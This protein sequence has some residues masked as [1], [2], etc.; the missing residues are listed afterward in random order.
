[1]ASE[2]LTQQASRGAL[3]ILSS[4]IAV[5]GI[6]FVGT[7]ILARLLTPKDFGLL[8]MANL[9]TGAVA[10]FGRFGLGAAIVHKKDV[11]HQ[12]LSTAFWAN[13][14]AGT[15]L[16]LT[17]VLIS[18]L[19]AL[20]FGEKVVMWVLIALA[21]NF[22]LTA[23][24]S[25]HS[26]LIYKRIEMKPLAVVEIASRSIRVGVM[27]VAAFAGLSFWSMVL[28]M[29]VER[30]F[31]TLAFFVIERWRPTFF[32]SVQRFKEMFR[33]GRNL[34]FGGFV[35]YLDQNI[36][37]ILTGRLLGA[38]LL[39]YFQM[40]YNLPT[41]LRQYLNDSVGVVSFPVFCKIQDDNERLVRGV[42]KII[43]FIAVGVLPILAGLSLTAHDFIL[44][45]YGKKWLPAVAPMQILCFG[46]ALTSINTVISPLF[47]AKGRP[48]I[49]LKWSLLRLPAMI[50]AVFIGVELGG[51]V[52]MAWGETIVEVLSLMM[53]YQAFRLLNEDLKPYFYALLPGGT[54][55]LVMVIALLL[56]NQLPW[57]SQTLPFVRL[58]IDV[59]CG[60][61][62]Y[63]ATLAFGFRET[64]ADA[65]KSVITRLHRT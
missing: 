28:G 24:C 6:S 44:I 2:S 63:T 1:M 17:C 39:G 27:L 43:R 4:N 38:E 9:V 40:S 61:L 18:P 8:G 52:G 65:W 58:L 14:A 15:I 46:A 26:T 51:L 50:L 45:V 35:G 29:I 21:M 54:S 31:K 7:A 23:M 32:F 13:T 49:D 36:D 30:F 59:A 20:F 37:F 62:I 48:D 60:A 33:Y 3:W 16:A 34:F 5:S 47:N 42:T 12:D 10:L 22:V 41:L 57:L 25:V 11:S 64:F 53:V 19:A 55:T 56:L